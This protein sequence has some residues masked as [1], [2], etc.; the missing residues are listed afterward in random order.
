MGGMAMENFIEVKAHNPQLH[1]GWNGQWKDLWKFLEILW[2]STLALLLLQFRFLLKKHM[3]YRYIFPTI[4]N[5]AKTSKYALMS[6]LFP[7]GWSNKSE[8]STEIWYYY[9][10]A[11]FSNFSY[12]ESFLTSSTYNN[13]KVRHLSIY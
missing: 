13:I 9:V 6:I 5:N 7:S 1:H 4:T 12:K 3:L 8:F 11:T 2:E 10:N